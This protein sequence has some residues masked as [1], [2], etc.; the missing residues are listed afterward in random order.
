MKFNI[1]YQSISP[2]VVATEIFSAYGKEIGE[3]FLKNA[4]SIKS[5][6][7]AN[8][9]DYLLTTPYYLNITELTLKHQFQ[10]Y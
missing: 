4:P 10:P 7:V 9:V 2:G 8:A 5:E 1:F 3:Q 6:D